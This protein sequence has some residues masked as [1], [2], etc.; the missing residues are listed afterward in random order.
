MGT[1]C[2]VVSTQV[3]EAGVDLDFPVVYRALAGLSSI[4]Q[5]AGR[6]NREGRLDKGRLIVFR[7]PKEPP[8]GT[9]RTAKHITESMLSI[10]RKLDVDDLQTIE[11]FFRQLYFTQELD[12]HGIQS[13]R[14]QLNF[15]NVGKKFHLIEDG[16]TSNIIVPYGGAIGL[17]ADI[18]QYGINRDS[19]RR[20]QRYVVNVYPDSLRQWNRGGAL[21]EIVEGLF[22][23]IDARLYDPIFGLVTGEQ[24]LPMT[25][26]V[27]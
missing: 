21:D 2:R 5:A 1:E 13:E 24:T 25:S 14:S 26:L 12:K 23:I 6:C 17:L 27:V 3:I 15:A 22:A 18:K 20:L 16:F 11:R 10:Q 4:I 19:M 7:P 9:L 8:V